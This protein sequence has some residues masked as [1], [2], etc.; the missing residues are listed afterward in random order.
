[1]RHRYTPG[2]VWTALRIIAAL[3]ATTWFTFGR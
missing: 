1:M 2:E 3:I